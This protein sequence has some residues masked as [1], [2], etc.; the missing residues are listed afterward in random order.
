M[1]LKEKKRSKPLPL[2]NALAST[3]LQIWQ[4]EALR[5]EGRIARDHGDAT[6]VILRRG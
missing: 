4:S 3:M 1:M 6:S 2:S 5:M